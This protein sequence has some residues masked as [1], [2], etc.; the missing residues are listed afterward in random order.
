M[1]EP[2]QVVVDT[3]VL[4]A[5]TRSS[6]GASQ[7]LLQELGSERWRMNVSTALLFEYEEQLTQL[8]GD[9]GIERNEVDELLN[10]IIKHSTQRLV[11]FLLRPNLRDPDDEFIVDL[12]VCAR[13]R[14]LYTF[15]K[16]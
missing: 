8:V 1:P 9:F 6:S 10:A 2:I 14:F 16:R 7:A 12:A 3:N 13:A 5:A 4:I 15:N 11:S